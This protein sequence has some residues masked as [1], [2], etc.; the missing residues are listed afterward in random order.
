ML[1]GGVEYNMCEK[2]F[3]GKILSPPPADEDD[4]LEETI[5]NDDISDEVDDAIVKP[6]KR[7]KRSKKTT[8]TTKKICK[9]CGEDIIKNENRDVLRFTNTYH[10]LS[11]KNYCE[12]HI[13]SYKD[14]GCKPCWCGDCGFL[15]KYEIIVKYDIMK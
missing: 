5:V 2:N 6:S 7:K 4:I 3:E 9:S 1:K 14:H 13:R 12:E 11:T 15:I 10:Q 8:K